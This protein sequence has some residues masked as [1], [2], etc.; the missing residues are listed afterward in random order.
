MQWAAGHDRRSL[1]PFVRRVVDAT[2]SEPHID[3]RSPERRFVLR[4]NSTEPSVTA[5]ARSLLPRTEVKPRLLPIAM[6]RSLTGARQL[7]PMKKSRRTARARIDQLVDR[8]LLLAEFDPLEL[9]EM[10]ATAEAKTLAAKG[11]ECRVFRPFGGTAGRACS[12]NTRG[13]LASALGQSPNQKLAFGR[14]EPPR[15]SPRRLDYSEMRW[16]SSGLDDKVDS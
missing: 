6:S 10:M 3:L 1:F 15:R 16:T 4:E 11:R 8:V 9:S 2:Q 13:L 7:R 5:W 14:V 12:T